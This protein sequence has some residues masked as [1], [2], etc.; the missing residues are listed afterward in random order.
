MSVWYFVR[1]PRERVVSVSVGLQPKSCK[2]PRE[3]LR[4]SLQVR[5]R[6]FFIVY[7]IFQLRN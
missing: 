5:E 7:C 4:E 6:S 2:G 3:R 1:A